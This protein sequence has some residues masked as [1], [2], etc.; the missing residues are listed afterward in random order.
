MYR[1]HM[2]EIRAGAGWMNPAG[3]WIWYW[4]R[5]AWNDMGT[6]PVA[7]SEHFWHAFHSPRPRRSS[8]SN[9]QCSLEGR[10]ERKCSPIAL[11]AVVRRDA[12]FTCPSWQHK[13]WAVPPG[14]SRE[15]PQPAA[16]EGVDTHAV[17]HGV[18]EAESKSRECDCEAFFHIDE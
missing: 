18:R 1:V 14:L 9:G 16:A 3:A 11:A 13:P 15:E 2:Q 10:E 5:F 12:T 17:G 4:C 6:A 8:V 7:H